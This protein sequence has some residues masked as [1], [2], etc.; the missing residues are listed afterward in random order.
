MMQIRH[1]FFINLALG[2]REQSAS[3]AAINIANGW[4]NAQTLCGPVLLV[5]YTVQREVI[6]DGKSVMQTQRIISVLLPED[7][8]VD[9]AAMEST[10]WRGIFEVPVYRANVGACRRLCQETRSRHWCRAMRP[11][12]GT[13]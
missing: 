5:P 3:I 8:N 10:R 4:G 1:L 9:I 7:L 12:C 2:D 13:R 6:S 11:S